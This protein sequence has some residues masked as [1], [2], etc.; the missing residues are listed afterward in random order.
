MSRSDSGSERR[1][2]ALV[3]VDE[4]IAGIS[5]AGRLPPETTKRYGDRGYNVGWQLSSV[6]SDGICRQLHV[7]AD[8]DFPYTPPRIAVADGPGVLAWPHLEEDGLLCVLPPDTAVSSQ[9]PAA[10]AACVLGDACALIEANISGSTEED[11]RQEFLSYW[12]LAADEGAP[13]F[14]STIDPKCQSQQIA[15]WREKKVRVVGESP[16]AL[17]RW[18]PRWGV[19]PGRGGEY[20]LC[21]GILIWL[22]KPL[23]PAEYPDTPADV[24]VLTQQHSPEVT[25][26]LEDLAMRCVSEVDVVLGARTAHG[27]CFGALVLKRPRQPPG[28]KRNS[29]PLVRGFRPGRVPAALLVARYFSGAAKATKAIVKRA[30]HLWIHGRDQDRRQERLRRARVAVLG[31]GSLGGPLA[32]LLAQ[33]GVGNLLLVDPAT[34][35]WPNVGRHELGAGSVGQSKAHELAREIEAAYPHLTEIS[36]RNKRVGMGESALMDELLTYDLVVS[37]M[38]NWAAES[39]LNDVQQES[40]G[41]PPIVYGWMEPHA[42]AAHAVVVPRVGACLRCG[43]N[44]KGRPNL[45]VTGWPNGGDSLQAPECGAMYTPYGPAELCWAHA[46]TSEAV[47]ETIVTQPATAHH[48]IWIGRRHRVVEVGGT[49]AATWIAEMGDPGAGGLTVERPW[50]Q[51]G[52]CPVCTRRMNAA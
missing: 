27:S 25:D 10:V 34:L 1:A 33:A 18:L 5:G 28:S 8:S 36:S 40:V 29:D 19:K 41:F 17:R 11:F 21:D 51:S 35:D 42:A 38:G 37:T 46:L 39:F 20:K 14:L 22:P 13:V 26:V 7:I 49:W 50:P 2:A 43:V 23:T 48:Y 44:D 3:Q 45:A 16:E 52:S 47:I 31:C 4:Y 15:V 12:A 24:R 6:F 9:N 32:R 30:D